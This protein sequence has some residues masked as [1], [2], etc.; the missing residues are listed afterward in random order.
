MTFSDETLMAYADDELDA[1]TRAAVDEAM[2][3]DPELASR[4]ARHRAL[5]QKLRG[6][7]DKVL[8]EPVPDR[9]VAA[10]RA[11]P[12]TRLESNVIPLRRK[13][14]RRWDWPHW[15]ALAASLVVG[16]MAGQLAVR[17]LDTGPVETRNGR[18]LASGSL[19]QALSHQLASNEAPAPVQIGVSFRSKSGDYCR[20]FALRDASAL[21]GLACRDRDA[22][23]VQVLTRG[24]TGPRSDGGYRPAASA[25]PRAVLQAVDEQISGDPLDASGEAAARAK[26]WSR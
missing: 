6:T 24:D 15:A 1:R 10:A 2:A 18:L 21:A 3:K 5:K 4:V 7:F 20:T 25:M 17:P 16:V 9:L 12:S 11:T 14:A 13:P 8:K 23:Q 26:E 19:A 22:W